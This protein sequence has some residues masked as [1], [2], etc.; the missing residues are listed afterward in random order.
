MIKYRPN[1][2]LAGQ[3]HAPGKHMCRSL[4]ACLNLSAALML[5]G[6][7]ACATSLA[8][9]YYD[10]GSA[11][12]ATTTQADVTHLRFALAEIRVAP[13]L[14]GNAMFY[15]LDFGNE[16]TQELRPFAQSRWSMPPAQLLAQRI[17]SRVTQGGGAVL[18]ANDGVRDLPLLKIELVEFS[19]IFSSPQE[20]QAQLHFRASLIV[21]NSLLAQRSFHAKHSAGSD[22]KSGSKAMLAASDASINDLLTWLATAGKH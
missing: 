2:T 4:R 18:N 22:A 17:K 10:F 14:D 15:R 6:L 11:G 20:S 16:S 8:V 13:S 5:A 21:Q 1:W 3:I 12:Q 7:G 9:Q 19:Q